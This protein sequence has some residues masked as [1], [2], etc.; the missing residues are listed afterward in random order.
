MTPIL[1]RLAILFI[2][3]SSGLVGGVALSRNHYRPLIADMK[4]KIAVEHQ[5]AAQ[6]VTKA[7]LDNDVLKSTLEVQHAQAN[8]ALNIL[9]SHPAPRVQLPTTPCPANNQVAASSGIPVQAPA[10][11]RASDTAQAA[12]NDAQAGM[13]SDAIEWRDAI[14]ACRPVMEWVKRTQ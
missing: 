11:E 5:E 13:E 1:W 9:L 12:F 14:E 6:A 7:V 8:E 2:I 3:A 10:A 4:L